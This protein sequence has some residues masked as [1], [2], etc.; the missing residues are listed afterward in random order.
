MNAAARVHLREVRERDGQ[1]SRG[2]KVDAQK[3]E[4]LR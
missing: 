4:A 3:T 2:E 1:L